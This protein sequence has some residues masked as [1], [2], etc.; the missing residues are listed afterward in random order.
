MDDIDIVAPV[1]EEYYEQVIH[2]LRHNFFPDEPLNNSVGLC[3]KG[4]PHKELEKISYETLKDELSIMAIHTP[5]NQVAAVAL[6]GILREGD[7]E[8]SIEKLDS[9]SDEKFKTIFSNLYAIN[10]SLNLF[11]RYEVDSVF[12]C[13]ILSVD[14][15]FRGKGLAIQLAEKSEELARSQGF[16]IFKTDTTGMFSQKTLL[17]LGHEPILEKK[18]EDILSEDGERVFNTSPPHESLKIMIKIL[19]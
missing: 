8:N 1:P 4:E 16:K 13:R 3:V 19:E 18:Y 5:T 7:I 17:K 14:S 12:E 15:E 9:V 6:N 2:H 10:K 11:Q